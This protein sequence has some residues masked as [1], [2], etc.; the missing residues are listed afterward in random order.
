MKSFVRTIAGKMGSYLLSISKE[1]E[2]V[3]KDDYV[4]EEEKTTVLDVV[5]G[6]FFKGGIVP[7]VSN[8]TKARGDFYVAGLNLTSLQCKKAGVRPAPWGNQTRYF[9]EISNM[10]KIMSK[11]ETIKPKIA[12]SQEWYYT[13]DNIDFIRGGSWA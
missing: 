2:S 12:T 8:K 9:G 11:I 4:Y 13:T 6:S 10:N 7:I 1:I 5:N 3:Q